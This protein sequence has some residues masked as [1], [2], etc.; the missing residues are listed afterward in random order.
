VA[1]PTRSPAPMP[2]GGAAAGKDLADAVGCR[3]HRQPTA[4]S[5]SCRRRSLSA[6]RCGTGLADTLVAGAP[7]PRERSRRRVGAKA[8]RRDGRAERISRTP[9]CWSTRQP[10]AES[11]SC[12]RRRLAAGRVH[13]TDLAVA[14]CRLP[15]AGCRL[16][17]AGCRLPVAG[18]RRTRQRSGR[19][20]GNPLFT[21]FPRHFRPCRRLRSDSVRPPKTSAARGLPGSHGPSATLAEP[22]EQTFSGGNR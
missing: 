18:C 10:T 16:P 5:P 20:V 9:G 11:L 6:G 17:V 8:S 1:C 12:R 2:R 15:V 3:A 4:G 22:D 14:G 7:D 19:P 13:G 21:P